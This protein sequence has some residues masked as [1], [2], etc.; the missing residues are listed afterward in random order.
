MSIET[1]KALVRRYIDDVLGHG[2]LD[3]IDEIFAPTMRPQVRRIAI[4]FRSAFPDMYET[5][6]DLL[7]EENKVAA[8]WTFH[9]TH[10]GEFLGVAPTGKS[11]TMSGMSFYL[12]EKGQILDDWAEWDQAGLLEQLK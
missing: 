8:R 12:I 1:N 2:H 10:W 11:V 9:G 4:R 3:A 6:E 7:A 5:I